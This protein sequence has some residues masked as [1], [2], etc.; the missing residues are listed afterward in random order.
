M[1]PHVHLQLYDSKPEQAVPVGGRQVQQVKPY[2]HPIKNAEF[3]FIFEFW[4]PQHHMLR[5]KF[6][7]DDRKN[8]TMETRES[9]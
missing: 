5:V 1:H 3:R 8:V 2:N 4:A 9:A 6:N 7:M